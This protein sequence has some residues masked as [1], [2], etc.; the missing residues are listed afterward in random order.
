MPLE[1]SLELQFLLEIQN[2]IP[3]SRSYFSGG[4]NDNR[5]WQP[6]SLGPG[7][8]GATNDFNEANMKIAISGEFR[9]KILGSLKGALF[10]DAGNIWNV[11]DNVADEKSTF[12]NLRDLKDIALGSGFGLRYDLSFFVIRFDLG[13]KTYNPA[14]ENSKR[15]FREY[16]FGHSV[17]NFG[18]NYPF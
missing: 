2:N 6:Y 3:F 10:A 7:S 4:S 11:L 14:N 13:F 1:L 9:F 17:L 16:N 5:A 12:T 15:W 8:S 18:I